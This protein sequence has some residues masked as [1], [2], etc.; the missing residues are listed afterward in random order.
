MKI[1]NSKFKIII[2]AILAAVAF[3]LFFFSKEKPKDLINLE[4]PIVKN[5]NEINQTE[6]MVQI[7][8]SWEV[9]GVKYNDAL[10][11]SKEEYDKLSAEEI[12][13]MKQERFENWARTVNG[14]SKR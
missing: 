12:E 9:D 10:Y 13:K 14:Q 3:S 6:E 2:V 1:G 11:I 7:K 5:Q 4:N 8:F